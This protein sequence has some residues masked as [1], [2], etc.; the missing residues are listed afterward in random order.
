M[1]TANSEPMDTAMR[2]NTGASQQMMSS[3]A[4]EPEGVSLTQKTRQSYHESL[5][6]NNRPSNAADDVPEEE[7]KLS[8]RQPDMHLTP[9]IKVAPLMTPDENTSTVPGSTPLPPQAMNEEQ[10]QR[11]RSMQTLQ[12]FGIRSG[13]KLAERRN[14]MNLKLRCTCKWSQNLAEPRKVDSLALLLL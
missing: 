14:K 10:K 3:E 13:S 6:D 5:P 8:P 7:V 12:N 9:Q 2:N 4:C 11:A 1:N